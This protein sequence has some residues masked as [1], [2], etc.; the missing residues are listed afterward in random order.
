MSIGLKSSSGGDEKQLEERV[1]DQRPPSALPQRKPGVFRVTAADVVKPTPPAL[2]R[3][4]TFEELGIADHFRKAVEEELTQG[5]KLVWLG[6]PSKNPAV[7]PPANK[8][9]LAIIGGV[10]LGFALL[11][12]IALKGMALI[13]PAV[14][15]LLGLLFIAA[16]WLPQAASQYKACYVITNRRAILLERILIMERRKSYY[17]HELMALECRNNPRVPG[18]GDLI[19]EYIFVVGNTGGIYPSLENTVT[20]TDAPQRKPR[21]FFFLDDARGVEQLIRT[22]LLANAE[23]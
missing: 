7:H 19:F 14:L 16:L 22:T 9:V 4:Q 18:A 20:R 1:T 3:L 11:L 10:V 21:G 15:A 8:A 13:I 2:P 5:E 6:Q 17:P 12:G 23:Q